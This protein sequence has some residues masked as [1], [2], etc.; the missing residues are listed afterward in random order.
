MQD[1]H[2]KTNTDV[3]LGR[4]RRRHKTRLRPKLKTPEVPRECR[5]RLCSSF[6][7]APAAPNVGAG[8]GNDQWEEVPAIP[9]LPAEPE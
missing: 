6:V 7:A 4:A 5:G 1:S 3:S 2:G 8:V 9:F